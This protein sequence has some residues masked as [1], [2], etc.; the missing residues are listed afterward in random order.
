VY[1]L[2]SSFRVLTFRHFVG[3]TAV[4]CPISDL[5]VIENDGDSLI[6][7]FL[8]FLKVLGTLRKSKQL[9]CVPDQVLSKYLKNYH[10]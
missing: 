2:I 9:I 1:K 10:E 6:K 5:K 4:G 7:I 3:K 8:V